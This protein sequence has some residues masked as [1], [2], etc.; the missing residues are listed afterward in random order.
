MMVIYRM[1]SQSA[2]I[3]PNKILKKQIQVSHEKGKKPYFPL[4]WLFNRDPYFMVYF[5][6][7]THNWVG[8][9]PLH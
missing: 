6:K 8:F 4:Y 2:K 7:S 5:K 9:H 3:S 1:G